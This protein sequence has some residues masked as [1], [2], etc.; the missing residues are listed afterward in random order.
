MTTLNRY[1]GKEIKAPNETKQNLLHVL[2]IL[3]ARER[4]HSKVNIRTFAANELTPRGLHIPFQE[5]QAAFEVLA[6]AGV[7][8]LSK[9]SMGRIEKAQFKE[10]A[11]QAAQKILGVHK[12]LATDHLVF[13]A[14]SGAGRGSN[15]TLEAAREVLLNDMPDSVKVKL[16]SALLLKE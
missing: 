9:G 7:C 11:R 4:D 12:I 3:A 6:G 16:L 13:S 10:S 14:D 15:K 5:V 1:N 8:K 2:R